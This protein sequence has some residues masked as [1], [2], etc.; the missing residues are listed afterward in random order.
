MFWSTTPSIMF[1][2]F[3]LI[4]NSFSFNNLNCTKKCQEI[5]ELSKIFKISNGHSHEA[6]HLTALL[7]Q[8]FGSKKARKY[9]C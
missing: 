2:K 1:G 3:S 8:Q 4:N 6:A 5:N 7:Y 9:K